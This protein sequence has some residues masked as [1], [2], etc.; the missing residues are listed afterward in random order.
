MLAR[1]VTLSGVGYWTCASTGTVVSIMTN[2]VV[3]VSW[4]LKLFRWSWCLT[5]CLSA[6]LQLHW[7]IHWQNWSLLDPTSVRAYTDMV[8]KMDYAILCD[9]TYWNTIFGISN[10]CAYGGIGPQSWLNPVF[11]SISTQYNPQ[12]CWRPCLSLRTGTVDP[13]SSTLALTQTTIFQ[14]S[15]HFAGNCIYKTFLLA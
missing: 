11:Q 14:E 7:R 5:C 12:N 3:K 1:L 10:H 13:E 15:L 2:Q 8:V 9:L 4:S 6:N